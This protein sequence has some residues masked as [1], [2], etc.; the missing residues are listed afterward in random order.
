MSELLNNYWHV[1]TFGYL[2]H[3]IRYLTLAG[4]AYLL[5]YVLWRRKM[6]GRKIQQLF[7][8]TS[9][10]RREILYSLLSLAIFASV[11]VLT[12]ALRKAGWI[13]LYL[14]IHLYGWA[15]L[16]FSVGA[17][18]L[19]HDTWFYWTHR[20]MH[21]RRLFPLMHR[22][23]HLSHNPTPWSAFAFHP[24]EALVQAIVFPVAAFF[25]PLH[26]LAAILWLL[27]MTIMNVLGHLGF[28]I[29][30]RGFVRNKLARWHNT[31]VHHNMHHRFVNYNFGL[32]FNIWDRLMKTN[33]PRYEEEYDRVTGES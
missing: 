2:G 7:P 30:P 25:M 8:N 17:L 12:V 28:E 27:Y 4:F 19:I 26:P 9:E 15:Y 3:L 13:Q 22:V 24:T 10:M 31:S 18:I 29:L 20:L 23:H 33:H 14:D 11:G 6:L 5:F 16:W 32:Y 1:F 21:T